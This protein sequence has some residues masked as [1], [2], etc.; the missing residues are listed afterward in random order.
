MRI[1]PRLIVV[2]GAL[3]AFGPL[4]IDFYLP[5]LPRLTTD[6]GTGASAGQLTLTACLLGLAVGQLVI[7]PL[8]D[9]FGRRPPL[10]AGL[11]AYLAASLACAAA[12]DIW[13]LVALRLVQGLGG[14][15]GIVVARSVVR[16]LVAGVAA[17]RL[18][19]I[20]MM[21][22]GVV[23]ILAPILG[24][25]F[26]H[27]TSWRGLFVILAVVDAGIL[28]ATARWLPETLSPE[29]RRR[30]G[31]TTGFR[32]LLGDRFFIAYAVVMGLA[33]ASMFS[34]IAGS[35]FVLEDI[36]GVSPQTYGL[37]F[38]VNALGI[39][40]AS[41]LNRAVVGRVSPQRMLLA[42]VGA[43]AAAGVILLSIVL[44]GRLGLAGILPCLFVA[45]ASMG[46][47]IPNATALALTDYPHAAG[48]ASAL[49][50]MLQFAFGAFAA[51]L[52]G[53]AGR[54][55][56]LPMALLMAAFG[57]GALAVLGVTSSRLRIRAVSPVRGG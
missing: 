11:V 48:S 20:L 35:S 17:A 29:R 33:F 13:V 21:V 8:S 44:A 19:S 30:V 42:G 32:E 45:V 7:G 10:L 3:S 38:G 16:D 22:I 52:V 47:V 5:G 36:H 15:A 1:S 14:S 51:P 56:A 12:P 23:P 54:E 34:Y 31:S 55:T 41:Q 46:L 39:V 18:Y 50:G 4:S 9:R 2:L 40:G 27:V 53:V 25:A 6:F 26:L 24:G 28:V 43:Q 37:L 57:V 49:L